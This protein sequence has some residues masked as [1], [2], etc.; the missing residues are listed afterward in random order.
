MTFIHHLYSTYHEYSIFRWNKDIQKTY[1]NEKYTLE[2]EK[3]TQLIQKNSQCFS[4]ALQFFNFDTP[5]PK[6]CP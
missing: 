4:E 5:E 1:I 6:Y 2:F 3:K